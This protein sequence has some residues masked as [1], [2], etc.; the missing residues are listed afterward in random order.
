MELLFSWNFY[1]GTT[2]QEYTR[3]LH[4]RIKEKLRKISGIF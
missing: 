3:F 2:V 1:A 4:K